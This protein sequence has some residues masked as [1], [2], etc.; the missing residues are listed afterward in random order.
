MKGEL[1]IIINKID[2][3]KRFLL[4]VFDLQSGLYLYKYYPASRILEEFG[5][6]SN[7]FENLFSSGNRHLNLSSY[8]KNGTGK[9][10]DGEPITVNFSEKTD[11]QQLQPVAQPVQQ[12]QP[13]QMMQHQNPNNDLLS[14]FGLNAPQIMDLFIEKNEASRL[15]T[16]CSELKAKV[17]KLQTENDTHR[18]YKLKNEYDWEKEK[19][20]REGTQGLIKDGLASLPMIM[21]HLKSDPSGLNGGQEINYGS[22]I[23]NNFA[24]QLKSIDDATLEILISIY[25][26][27]S[28][29]PAFSSELIALLQKHKLWE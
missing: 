25:K 5:T 22:L 2:T 27:S 20:K 14:S 19:S 24:E 13:V 4:S 28:T 9:V 18:E 16:E 17:E 7:F 23:K 21:A 11:E 10:K 29:N 15:R 26:A 12:M 8:R 3:D 6:G 1:E